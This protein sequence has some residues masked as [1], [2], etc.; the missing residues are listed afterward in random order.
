MRKSTTLARMTK[1][2][3]REIP[4][5]LFQSVQFPALI[6][7]SSMLYQ[8]ESQL[9]YL[10]DHT[11]SSPAH[12]SRL[13]RRVGCMDLG[14]CCSIYSVYSI[15]FPSQTPIPKSSSPVFAP[16]PSQ[17]H[18]PRAGAITT[19]HHLI[20]AVHEMHGKLVSLLQVDHI[21][22]DAPQQTLLF[23][24]VRVSLFGLGRMVH[25]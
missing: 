22:R 25:L 1:N 10:I 7:T 9:V 12:C 13:A 4:K 19:Q 16:W 14:F 11:Q 21:N 2:H 6:T 20:K 18:N 3:S 15:Y 23:I 8:V 5:P 17:K 24:F